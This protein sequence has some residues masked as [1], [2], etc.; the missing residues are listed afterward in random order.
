MAPARHTSAQQRARTPAIC[1][2][3]NQFACVKAQLAARPAY[4]AA[5]EAAAGATAN[6]A[7]GAT[8]T[9]SSGMASAAA[10]T[11]AAT[12]SAVADAIPCRRHSSR[13]V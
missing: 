8:A 9:S 13:C 6:T 3:A 4:T 2:L 5:G 11:A 7:A 1:T 10:V 12:T